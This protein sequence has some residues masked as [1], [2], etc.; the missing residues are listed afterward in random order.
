MKLTAIFIRRRSGGSGQPRFRQNGEIFTFRDYGNQITTAVVL[1]AGT[2]KLQ[3]QFPVGV[4]VKI[5]LINLVDG[6]SETLIIRSGIGSQVFRILDAGRYAFQ[7]E[8]VDE[9]S[10]W[11]FEISPLGLPSRRE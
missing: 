5:D 9:Q 3:Y 4:A 7:V 8:P 1:Q 10:E 2:Y 11:S 6:D